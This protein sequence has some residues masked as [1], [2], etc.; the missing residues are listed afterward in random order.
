MSGFND[1]QNH[2]LFDLTG[3]ANAPV[4]RAATVLSMIGQAEELVRL[5]YLRVEAVKLRATSY[6]NQRPDILTYFTCH[7]V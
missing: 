4:L 7:N 6:N 2:S 1:S 5:V 3:V